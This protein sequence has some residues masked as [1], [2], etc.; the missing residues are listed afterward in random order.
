MSSKSLKEIIVFTAGD[1]LIRDIIDFLEE[2]GID[3]IHPQIPK[4]REQFNKEFNSVKYE[5]NT[6]TIVDMYDLFLNL[7]FDI[8]LEEDL[9]FDK[10]K[11]IRMF[12]ESYSEFMSN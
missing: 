4:L 10:Q 11:Y 3:E 8:E 2:E 6:L 7:D 1:Q 12:E 5:N 9:Y